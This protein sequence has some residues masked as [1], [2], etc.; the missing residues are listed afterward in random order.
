MSSPPPAP[1]LDPALAPLLAA[2]SPAEI[3]AARTRILSAVVPVLEA[4]LRQRSAYHRVSRE[5]AEDVRS[6]ALERVV[7]ALESVREGQGAVVISRFEAYAATCARMA[8]LDF[9]RAR[10]P[11]RVRLL[12]Q[13]RF[14]LEGR[15]GDRRFQWREDASGEGRAGLAG[16][17]D[18]ASPEMQAR[19]RADPAGTIQHWHG[20]GVELAHLP[21]PAMLER[22]LRSAGGLLPFEA[23]LDALAAARGIVDP[24]ALTTP[25]QPEEPPDATFNPRESAEW[26]D[27]LRWLWTALQ[28]LSLRQRTAFL[29]HVPVTADL[30]AEG[31]ASLRQL[32]AALEIDPLE[33]ARLWVEIP[34]DDRQI[35]ERLGLERQQVT[36]LRRVA[37]D[38]LGRAW[39]EMKSAQP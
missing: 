27:H 18:E 5:D 2:T 29:L 33:F 11:E 26:R 10:A 36:N 28:R 37:R 13:L 19:L 24:L 1:Q 12:H 15:A 23:L 20:A 6:A 35:G 8:W 21:L 9:Q 39:R 34:L 32:A 22:V 30:E 3:E 16:Q 25:W 14:L 7:R 38:A 31:I 17:T 4:T